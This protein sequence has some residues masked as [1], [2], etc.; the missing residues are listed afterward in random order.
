M[1][2]SSGN[3]FRKGLKLRALGFIGEFGILVG[4]GGR[5]DDIALLGS[6]PEELQIL[7][8]LVVPTVDRGLLNGGW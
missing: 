3:V 2:V 8:R 7:A 4:C 1:L 6:P 5:G